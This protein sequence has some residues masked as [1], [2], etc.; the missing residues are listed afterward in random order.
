MACL[1]CVPPGKWVSKI[2][3]KVIAKI[4]QLRGPVRNTADTNN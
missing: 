4:A 1:T 3:E 2:F